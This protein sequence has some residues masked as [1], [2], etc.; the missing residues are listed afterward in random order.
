MPLVETRQKN[1]KCFWVKGPLKHEKL[2]KLVSKAEKLLTSLNYIGIIAF[3]LFEAQNGELLVNEVAPR[4]HNSGHHSINTLPLSQFDLHL[5]AIMNLEMPKNQEAYLPFSMVNLIGSSSNKPSLQ[6]P[7]KAHLHWYGKKD[8]R[9]GRKMGHMT[10]L[11]KT[12]DKALSYLLR[13]LKKQVL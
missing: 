13:Q 8:N 10:G 5:M 1:S 2:S 3:E 12:A 6:L 9:D 4:V 11:D 7:E